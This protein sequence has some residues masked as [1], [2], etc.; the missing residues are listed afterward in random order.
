MKLHIYGGPGSGK[1]TLGLEY[2][3]RYKLKY[4][5]LD[6]IFWDQRNG[7]YTKINSVEV[8]QYAL[9]K[10]IENNENWVIEGVYIDW[11]YDSLSQADKILILNTNSLV[12]GYRIIKR[13]IFRKKNKS[14]K[15]ETLKS[16]VQLLIWNFKFQNKL[17]RNINRM[18]TLYERKVKIIKN[19]NYEPD[20]L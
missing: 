16:L 15:A 3:R 12:R 10:F 11:V 8:R 14:K 17:K 2:S 18:K 9:K 13:Y 19:T 20:E 6:S 5:D 1:T 4:L 7:K